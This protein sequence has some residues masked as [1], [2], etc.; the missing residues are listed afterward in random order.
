MPDSTVSALPLLATLLGSEAIYG[1]ENPGKANARDVHFMASALQNYLAGLTELSFSEA[2]P[3]TPSDNDLWWQ[4]STNIL[5]LWS[6]TAWVKI[7]GSE[8]NISVTFADTAP[9]NPEAGDFWVNG[10]ALSTY[11]GTAWIDIAS[12]VLD[13]NSVTSAQLKASTATQKN[14]FL[15]R[16][17]ALKTDLSNIASLTTTQARA[18]RVALGALSP[19]SPALTGA[20]TT[21][22]P[23][24]SSGDTQIANKAYVIAQI[25]ALVNS[26]PETLRTLNALSAALADSADIINVVNLLALKAPLASPALTGSP[27][28]PTPQSSDGD[29]QIANKAYV[30]AQISALVDSSPDA[31]NTLNE[32]AAALDDNASYATTITNALALKAPLASPALTGAPTTPTP[33]SD[34][35]D[36]QIANKK[37]VTDTPPAGSAIK[38]AYESQGDTNAFTDA[39]KTKLEA[40]TVPAGPIVLATAGEV[41]GSSPDAV[42]LAQDLVNGW[43]LEIIAN[44]TEVGA[45]AGYITSNAIL[46]RTTAY[47]TTAP[48]VTD[49]QSLAV[50]IHRAGTTEFSHSSVLLWKH[51]DA[52]KIW[53]SDGRR[54]SQSYRIV[55]YSLGG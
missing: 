52:D 1:V 17:T 37:Y 28:A 54:A 19:V 53:M 29:T 32:L 42:E 13:D 43:L 35:G 36:T 24:S 25:T 10:T 27:T 30:I 16:L 20:P 2:A 26:S 44:N 8:T 5:S 18:A 39:L 3:S 45:A 55:A 31:L 4:I 14:A 48:T 23:Q 40:L 21:P 46:S 51:D 33:Q 7:T 47:G 6:G 50:K 11:S 49:A 41:A 15:A 38:T 22:T 12:G 34:S 9:A